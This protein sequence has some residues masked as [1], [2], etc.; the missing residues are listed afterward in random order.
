VIF[1]FLNLI[2]MTPVRW[3]NECQVRAKYKPA[4]KMCWSPDIDPLALH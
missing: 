3:S 2:T 1:S 4:A